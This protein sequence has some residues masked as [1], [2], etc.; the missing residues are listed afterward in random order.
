[1]PIRIRLA[2][3]FAVVT[4]VILSL[5]GFLFLRSFR[6]GLEASL[7]PG[8]RSNADALAQQV[9][10]EGS[11]LD[12]QV[13]S[14]GVRTNDA[15]AQVIEPDGAV[16]TATREAGVHPIVSAPVLEDARRR[17][18]TERVELGREREPFELLVRSVAGRPGNFVVVGTSLEATDEAVTRVRTALVVG[19]ALTVVL[20]AVGAWFL[21]R[22]A[23]RPV[24][25][26]RRGADEISEHDLGRR[27]EVPTTHDEIAAL[28]VT[29]N[30][31]LERLQ[32]ALVRQR[33]F[34]ADAGH[35]LR[36]PLAILS[37]ELE[38]ADRSGR[39]R[40]E[41]LDSIK[42]ARDETRRLRQLAEE[43]LFLAGNDSGVA[44]GRSAPMT[45]VIESS[46]AS[47]Q[48]RAEQHQTTLELTGDLRTETRVEPTSFRRAIDNLV[49][50]ALRY[51]PSG[52]TVRVRLRTDGRDAHV[53]VIDEGPGFP[54][55]FL[56][57]AFE[58]FRRGDDARSRGDGGTGLGLAIVLAVAQR[59]GGTA[60]AQNR[61]A[62]GA[63]VT[64]CIPRR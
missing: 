17:A 39:T 45:S 7:R 41:L 29:M 36:T 26:M 23:L 30:E 11:R 56:P 57:A 50:N 58:R 13:S 4:L 38:L 31:L 62:G 44:D 6:Q 37:T 35:E 2:V 32:R 55:P 48:T 8:L 52:T 9:R 14:P 33:A 63:I 3:F 60:S 18:T 19:T 12:L 34:V 42:N 27:L 24:E 25:R 47:F 51:A 22:A 10:A 21:A 53:E 43:L 40:D 46:L 1:M 61:A 16:V 15:V 59:H 64:I 5:A 54:V 28:G 20:A 49:D